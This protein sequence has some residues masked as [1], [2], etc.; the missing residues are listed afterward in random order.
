LEVS[1]KILSRSPENSCPEPYASPHRRPIQTTQ[2]AKA[3]FAYGIWIKI[4][5]GTGQSNGAEG[6]DSFDMHPIPKDRTASVIFGHNLLVDMVLK[7]SSRRKRFS[8]V[9]LLISLP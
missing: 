5:N 4:K 6:F 3:L 1:S 7:V 8:R 9:A 2:I